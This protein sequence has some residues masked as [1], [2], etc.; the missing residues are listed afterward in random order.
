MDMLAGLYLTG[1]W[2]IFIFSCVR[3]FIAIT[4]GAFKEAAISGSVA[5]VLFLILV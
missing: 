5:I 4:A 1:C 3:A 2:L